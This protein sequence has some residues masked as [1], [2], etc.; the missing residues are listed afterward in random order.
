[1]RLGPSLFLLFRLVGAC[2][3]VGTG[4]LH[5]W[6]WV[7]ARASARCGGY[8]LKDLGRGVARYGGDLLNNSGGGGGGRHAEM[9]LGNV[10]VRAGGVCS[11]I[12][13]GR[14]VIAFWATN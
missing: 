9:G 7:E 12:G 2:E 13:G 11:N 8:V 1:M 14:A 3:V 5:W 6:R 4:T 10:R